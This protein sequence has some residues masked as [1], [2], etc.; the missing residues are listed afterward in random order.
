MNEIIIGGI[1]LIILVAAILAGRQ[2]GLE[3]V[4]S[5]RDTIDAEKEAW[6]EESVLSY[7]EVQ[8]LRQDLIDAVH[9]RLVDHPEDEELLKQIINDWADLKIESYQERRSWVRSPDQPTDE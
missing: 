2:R 7:E 3:H 9:G 5:H 4:Q 8:L 6:A 1:I